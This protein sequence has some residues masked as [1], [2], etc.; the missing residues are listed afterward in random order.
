MRSTTGNAGPSEGLQMTM[1]ATALFLA[2]ARSGAVVCVSPAA[3][4]VRVYHKEG[5]P[6]SMLAEMMARKPELFEAVIENGLE[7]RGEYYA[8]A[9]AHFGVPE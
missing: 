8:W 4:E 6:E 7:H 2:V 5:L 9:P 3:Y 1:D